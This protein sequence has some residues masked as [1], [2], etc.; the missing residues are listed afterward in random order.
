MMQGNEQSMG[1]AR[2]V[3]GN[4]LI[5]LGGIALIGSAAAKF[6]HVTKVVEQLAASGFYGERLTLIAGLEVV[7]AVLFLIPSTRAAGLLLV[8]AFLGGAIATHV[9]HGLPM[10]QPAVFLFVLWLGAWLRHPQILWSIRDRTLGEM[11]YPTSDRRP[12]M[13]G[14]I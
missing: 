11:Q 2:R 3:A 10:A 7:S 4:I 1:A 14:Q 5:G 13:S 9:Q 8:S 12:K 6:A